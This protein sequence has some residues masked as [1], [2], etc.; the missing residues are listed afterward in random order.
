MGWWR[1]CASAWVGWRAKAVRA[2]PA[3]IL[4]AATVMRPDLTRTP[5]PT[6]LLPLQ[7]AAWAISNATSGG[8]AEQI[9]YL[10]AAG[11]VR[12]LC[13][14]LACADARIVIVAL[15][16]LENILKVGEAEKELAGPAGVN[17]FVALVDE[18]EGLDKIEELQNHTNEDVYDKAVSVLE[19]FF[20]V[21]DGAEV[22]NL[23][24]ARGGARI[25]GHHQDGLAR[26]AVQ[27]LEKV[28]HRIARLAV[29]VA[30][31]LV[32]QQEQRIGDDGARDADP[33][34]L[35]AG[36]FG[37]A[38]PGA[39]GKTDECQRR[40]GAAQPLGG[41]QVGQQQRQLDIALGGQHRQQVVGLEDEADVA[42]APAGE[43]GVAQPVDRQA[44][45]L[46]AARGRP[47]EAA[48]QVEERALARS[49]RPHQRDVVT[50]G[51]VEVEE[52]AQYLYDHGIPAYAYSTELPVEVLGAKYKWA[53]GAGLL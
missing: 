34:F 14:L 36:Q 41:R 37:R 19:A 50:A 33:L 30:G 15:E 35:A 18:A 2:G 5:P 16:G 46:D 43:I 26:L 24:P 20:D 32:A 9:R 13:D 7:E 40:A 39:V 1:G 23:A 47:V 25:V 53:R 11:C 29:E 8:S 45:D 21:E 31:R 49:G 10:V 17:P 27:R 28:E 42:R 38:V 44:L 6:L 4:M 48:D 51:D 3:L 12:P 52:A 22:E